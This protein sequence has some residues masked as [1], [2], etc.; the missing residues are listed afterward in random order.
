MEYRKRVVD[1]A[2][3]ALLG[4]SGAVLIEGAKGCGKTSTATQAA[5]SVLRVDVDP[6]VEMFLQTEPERVLRGDK[7]L[8]LDEWQRQPKLWDMVRRAVD[9]SQR[10]GQF[11]LTGSATPNAAVP[12]HSGAGRFS[13][14][15]MRPMTLWE[16]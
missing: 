6:T 16:M 1:T 15:R 10:P 12:R 3:Q 5:A 4:R 9:D 8:L 13:I 2:L 14:L 7:P 11:I